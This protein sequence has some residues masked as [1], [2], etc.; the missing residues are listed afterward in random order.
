MVLL[1]K[2]L[3]VK[4]PSPALLLLFYLGSGE[5]PKLTAQYLPLLLLLL[6][7]EAPKKFSLHLPW[8]LLLSLN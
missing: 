3:F 7:D 6:L 4:V 1:S 8:V 5:A 2:I